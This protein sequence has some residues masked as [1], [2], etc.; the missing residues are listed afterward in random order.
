[1][2]GTYG[3]SCKKYINSSSHSGQF[4]TPTISTFHSANYKRMI[5]NLLQSSKKTSTL[6]LYFDYHFCY[7]KKPNTKKMKKIILSLLLLSGTYTLMAQEANTSMNKSADLGITA[8][9]YAALPVLETNVPQDIIDKMKSK[10]GDALYD[11][12]TIV[13]TSGQTQYVVRSLKN[14]Q[15]ETDYVSEDGTPSS[16]TNK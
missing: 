11:I 8:T 3:N 2:H 6:A 15:Y 5:F 10:Y 14:G 1:L 4:Y 16:L 7:F 13:G 9:T 12:T